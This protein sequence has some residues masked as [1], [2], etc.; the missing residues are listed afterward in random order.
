[1]AAMKRMRLTDAA[2]ARLRSREREYTV[3][4]SRVP[5]FGIRVRPS[6]G[7]SYVLLCD[8]GG[9]SSRVSLG[10]VSTMSIAQARREWLAR[11]AAHEPDKETAPTH[12]VPLLREFVEGEWKEAHFERYKPSTKKGVR[13]LLTGRILPAFGSK[14]LDRITPA[15][16]RRWFDAFSRTAPGN[17]NHALDLLRQIMNFAVACSHVEKNPA[18]GIRPN[19]RSRLTRFL[20]REEIGRPAPGPRQADPERWPGAG[21]QPTT[22]RILRPISKAS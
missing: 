20:S 15:R 12:A 9:R 8:A 17:A 5:G 3:W 19:R 22:K 2:I 18:Q 1:M 11:Q 21:G 13:S 7:L 10:P 4:D 16:L 6:G 14:R